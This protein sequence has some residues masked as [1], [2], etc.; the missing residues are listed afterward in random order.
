[1]AKKK[2]IKKAAPPASK[3]KDAIKKVGQNNELGGMAPTRM[4]GKG[5]SAA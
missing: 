2:Q 3:K 5:V 4:L 1:M